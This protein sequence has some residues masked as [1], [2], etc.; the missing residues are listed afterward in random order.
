M[1]MTEFD[2]FFFVLKV[3]NFK[4][5]QSEEVKQKDSLVIYEVFFSRA[6]KS[7]VAYN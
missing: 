3:S 4:F 1:K 2:C 7:E 5:N 6:L